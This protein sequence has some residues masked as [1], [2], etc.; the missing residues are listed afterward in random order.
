MRTGRV[1]RLA[2]LL[3]ACGPGR[4][5][6]RRRAGGLADGRRRRSYTP[7]LDMKDAACVANFYR[8]RLSR[9]AWLTPY[10]KLTP[11]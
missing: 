6:C 10:F 1:W 2:L 11:A 3:L 5:R 7:G 8:G 4:G 9:K